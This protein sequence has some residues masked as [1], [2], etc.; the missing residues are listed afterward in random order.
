MRRRRAVA[1]AVALLCGGPAGARAQAPCNFWVAPPPVGNDANPGTQAQPWATLNFASAQVLALGQSG[2]TVCFMN[3]VY[4]GANSLYERFTSPTTFRA[5]TTYRAVLQNSGTAVSLFGARNMVFEGFEL[6]HSGPGAGALVIQ[7]QQDGVNWSEDVVFRNNILHDSWNN[8]I[9]KINNGARF[10]TVEGNVFYN[11]TGSD[12]HIDINGVTDVVVQDN[13]F[14]N[15]FAGSGRPNNNDTSSYIVIKD[16]GALING[17][18]R[19]TV[20]RNVFLNWEGSGGSN[21]LL[22]GEDGQPFYEAQ[23]ILVQNNLMIG[24]SG[25]LMRAAFGVKGGQGI[26]FRN[27]TVV[28][29]LP[30]LA[31]AFR[32]NQEGQNPVNLNVLFHNNIW[33]DPAGTMGAE[34]GGGNDF[35]DGSPAEVAALVLD[36]NLYWNGGAAIPPGDQVNPNVDDTRRII[37]NPQLN[38]NQA[39]VVLPHWNGT[40]F[41]SGNTTIRQEFV[42]LVNLYGAIPAGSPGHNQADVFLAP[43][44]DILGNTRVLPDMGAY[45]VMVPPSLSIGDVTVTEGNAGSVTAT[46]TVTLSAAAAQP[47]TVQFATAD[48][49]AAAGADYVAGSGTLSVPA[50]AMSGVVSVA[51]LGDLLDEDDETFS[52]NLSNPTGA[53]IS[54]GQ[55]IGTITDNDPLPFLFAGDCAVAEGNTGTTPCPFVVTLSPASGKTVTVS[56]ATANG[57]AQAGSDYTSARGG[58]SFP[59]G[60][61]QQTVAV[62]VLGDTVPEPDESF[63]VN[64]SAA[65]NAAVADPQG[66]GTILDDDAPSLSSLEVSH[67]TQLSADLSGGTPDA[68]RLSQRPLSSYEVVVD[69]L[70]GD[71]VPGLLLERVAADNVTVAQ[72]AVAV[73]TG[74]ALS[75]RWENSVAATVNAQTIRL[76]SPACGTGCGADDIYRMRVY[77]T[78]MSVARF[79]NSGSQVTVLVLQNPSSQPVTGHVHFWAA[80]GTLLLSQPVTLAP[81]AVIVFNTALLPLLPGQGGSVTLSHDAPYA[82]LIGKTVALEPATGFSFDSPLEPRPK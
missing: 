65:S 74:T 45:E 82:A 22:L 26:H 5:E 52:V 61:T 16:S 34:G 17:S 25:N 18:A 58:L 54:D 46:F 32:I 11:Q 79:N 60:T 55:G 75:L 2:A 19:I 72:T 8:D 38:T 66:V 40:A 7:V 10:I 15:D 50:G 29:N 37:A 47:V 59:P 76:R 68:Y 51:V 48:G 57:T 24:N 30:T 42:R 36:R 39:G 73:G 23:D 77:D 56:Y 20:Q 31:Y 67:G 35:S 64:L 13:V 80:S 41:P 9:L 6:R 81:K 27:N 33:S 28:G 4:T 12:E 71:A 63:A 14:F 70:S 62:D 49:T 44:D 78:T 53:T 3:G 43:P 69:E 1:F 21:F